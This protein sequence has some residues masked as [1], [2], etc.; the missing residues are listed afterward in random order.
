MSKNH[1]EIAAED[2]SDVCENE[3]AKQK[4]AHSTTSFI[5]K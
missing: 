2:E 3:N 4:I 1:N 5:N